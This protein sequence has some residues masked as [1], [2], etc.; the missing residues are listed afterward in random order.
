MLQPPNVTTPLRCRAWPRAWQPARR[1]GGRRA[2]RRDV[3]AVRRRS[4]RACVQRAD[5]V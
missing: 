1:G 5:L 4:A 2:Q 3:R